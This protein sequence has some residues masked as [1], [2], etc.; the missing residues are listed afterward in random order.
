MPSGHE[1]P[2]QFTEK[3]A[4]LDEPCSSALKIR[5]IHTSY[6]HPYGAVHETY[7]TGVPYSAWQCEEHRLLETQLLYLTSGNIQFVN[8]AI[9]RTEAPLSRISPASSWLNIVFTTQLQQ[10]QVTTPALGPCEL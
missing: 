5:N 8:L 6:M 3:G 1:Y 4:P 9:S 7:S 10:L 2:I